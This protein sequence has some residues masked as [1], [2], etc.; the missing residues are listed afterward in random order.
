ML[1]RGSIGNAA[2]AHA[3]TNALLVVWVLIGNHWQ[4]W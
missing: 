2:A 3:T 4:Y 1:R